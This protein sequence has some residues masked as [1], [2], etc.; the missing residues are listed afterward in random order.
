[1][2][3]FLRIRLINAGGAGDTAANDTTLQIFFIANLKQTGCGGSCPP[4]GTCAPV[5]P[6]NRRA[7]CHTYLVL[8]LRKQV[9]LSRFTRPILLVYFNWRLYCQR[10][11]KKIHMIICY[12]SDNF[13]N[14]II[15]FRYRQLDT[16]I[17]VHIKFTKNRYFYVKLNKEI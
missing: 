9:S 2:R 10:G 15:R 12:A 11:L 13:K 8:L 5:R 17:K 6:S 4:R 14:G 7:D 3:R 1:M 16:Y